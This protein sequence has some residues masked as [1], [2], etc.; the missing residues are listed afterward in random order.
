MAADGPA[1]NGRAVHRGDN[2]SLQAG[3]SSPSGAGRRLPVTSTDVARLAGCSFGVTAP[4]ALRPV[5]EALVVEMGGEPV[6]IADDMRPLY[7]AALASGANLAFG[8]DS[9]VETM[10]PLAG[11]HAAVTRRNAAGEPRDGWYP[12][13]RISVEAPIFQDLIAFW[14]SVADG[15]PFP[16]SPGD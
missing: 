9:P 16:S 5:A 6:W 8:S 14:G 15:R 2:M 3:R 13:E 1:R 10:D 4:E 12:N 11:L 7:H